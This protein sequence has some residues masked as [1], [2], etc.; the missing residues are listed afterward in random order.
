MDW[1][2]LVGVE[3][4]E[5]EVDGPW[6]QVVS[7]AEVVG[8]VVDVVGDER[9]RRSQSEAVS[10]MTSSPSDSKRMNLGEMSRK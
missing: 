8:V 10:R 9:K 2:F 4:E 6:V 5:E 3:G 7:A 1:H